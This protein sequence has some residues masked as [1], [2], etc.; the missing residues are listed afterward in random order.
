MYV[1]YLMSHGQKHQD[2]SNSD[3]AKIPNQSRLIQNSRM[4]VINNESRAFGKIS[5]HNM[6]VN[7][8][9]PWSTG[10]SKA[11]L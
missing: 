2:G 10:W 5:V 11:A 6:F 7:E 4:C 8:M 3:K 1:W 9:W